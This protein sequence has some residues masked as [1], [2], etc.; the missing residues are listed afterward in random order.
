MKAAL[1]RNRGFAEADGH[2][3][4]SL[5]PVMGLLVLTCLDARLDPAHIL[6]LELGDAL[7]IRNNGGRVTPQTLN[8]LAY[9]SQLAEAARPEGDLFEIAVIQ[10]TQCGAARLTDDGFRRQYADRIGADE[11]QLVE[12]AIVDP[13]ATVAA[14]VKRLRDA[15]IISPRIGVSGHV[16][17]V[18][19]GLIETVVDANPGPERL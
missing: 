7:V 3:N 6:D 19:T 17:D 4:A 2:K 12:Y 8:D 13:V 5:F 18:A 14:D 16:Y 1:S 10:H 15:D 9:V 11:A